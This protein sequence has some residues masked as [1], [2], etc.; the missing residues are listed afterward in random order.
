MAENT[1]DAM[2]QTSQS[3][4]ATMPVNGMDAAIAQMQ[5]YSYIAGALALVLT[6]LFVVSGWKLNTK[7]GKPGWATLVPIYNVLVF[8]DIVGR[9]AWWLV[10]LLIPGVNLI[11][12]IV[13]MFDLAKAYGKG[14]GYGFGLLLFSWI[15]YPA[16]AFGSAKYQGENA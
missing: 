5:M 6:V 10:L 11:V 3:A 12:S 15:F 16:L 1:V 4:A 8:L 7:A 14:A 9:P 2:Y 13:L